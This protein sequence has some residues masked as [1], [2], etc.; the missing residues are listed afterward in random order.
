MTSR[1]GAARNR[2]VDVLVV[3]A[4]VLPS[5]VLAS[6]TLIRG[7]EADL[8]P[9][10]PHVDHLTR[11]S[12]VCPTPAVRPAGDVR[13]TRTPGAA[14]GEVAVRIAE[15][16]RTTGAGRVGADQGVNPIDGR[17]AAT[18][19]TGRGDAAPGLVAGRDER[20][21]I[22]E[23]RAPW[24]D[25]WFVGLGAATRE[26]SVIELVNPDPS[27]AVVDIEIHG[28]DGPLEDA[29]WRGVT[30]PAHG[31][32][33]VRLSEHPV[34]AAVA[35]HVTVSRGRISASARH[36]W[37]ALGRATATTDYVP[38]QSQAA[39]ENLLLGVPERGQRRRLHLANPGD[40]EVRVRIHVVTEDATFVPT[41]TD[42]V[43]VPPRSQVA[44]GLNDSLDADAA[45]G[46]LGLLI[47]STDPV[48]AGVRTLVD[49]DLLTVGP[50][51]VHDEPLVA[52]APGGDQS[53]VVAGATRAGTV[54]ITAV[55]AGGRVI[56]DEKR[57][58]IDPGHAMEVELP[59]RAARI[60]VTARNTP[61]AAT[62]LATDAGGSAAARL[63][64]A[65]THAEVPDVRPGG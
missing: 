63:F 20:G 61:I 65:R 17:R 33:W 59:P 31:V 40:D 9:T 46:A 36:T 18:V 29:S 26:S 14:G 45:A 58:E 23:C 4:M 47:E 15:G 57:F 21:A 25:E 1:A 13:V 6:L 5:V 11:A 32:E 39:T 43:S 10:P 2:R 34:R 44:V 49:G 3:L 51:A 28:P 48:V 54:R 41:G 38:A 55:A 8:V 24:Y 27:V 64:P 62:L 19:L 50:A 37:D 7:E 56:W 52:L 22:P 53:L 35:A 42:E 60:V 30:V 16:D 12:L